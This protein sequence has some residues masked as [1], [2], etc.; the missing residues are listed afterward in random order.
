MS[1]APIFTPAAC[2]EYPVPQALH[3]SD[4]T[5]Q[6][7][8]VFSFYFILTTN[9]QF[10]IL[11]VRERFKL[12]QLP[13]D[14]LSHIDPLS[15][16]R[17]GLDSCLLAL[18]L[19]SLCIICI[20]STP[21][22]LPSS[23]LPHA[24]QKHMHS[25]SHSQSSLS[26]WRPDAAE[27]LVPSIEEHLD[28]TPS[29]H[30]HLHD[31]SHSHSHSHHAHTESHAPNRSA[32]L[33]IDRPRPMSLDVMGGWTLEETTSGKSVIAHDGEP[34]PAT[35]YSPP[36]EI[37]NIQYN[38]PHDNNTERSIFTAALLPF[39]AKFP[40]LHAIMTEKDSRR[41]FYFMLCVMNCDAT[42]CWPSLPQC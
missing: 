11:A 17:H 13:A 35:P 6:R 8:S 20:M 36:Q 32:T 33:T 25:H 26:A 41:I 14:P 24:H 9:H 10:S 38:L 39:T 4:R 37:H 23:A 30:T 18:A 5:P 28:D 2:Q 19:S 3:R 40:I 34:A 16:A 29:Q 42:S 31:H 1:F 21:Y 7:S 12:P 22:T 27:N 15:V